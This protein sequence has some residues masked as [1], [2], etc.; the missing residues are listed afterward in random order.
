[1]EWAMNREDEEHVTLPNFI[2]QFS[3]SNRDESTQAF[4]QLIHCREIR[5]SRRQNLQ[6][7]FALF[8]AQH[9][10]RFWAQ[11]E[12]EVSSEVRSERAGLAAQ[13]AAVVQSDIAF[14]QIVSTLSQC[15]GGEH[16]GKGNACCI[17]H[18]NQAL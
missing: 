2:T 17:S 7:T 14:K 16:D 9:E 5:E 18:T 13:G 3:L 1:M 12:L 10:E 15:M 8:C 6:N 4:R 11:R